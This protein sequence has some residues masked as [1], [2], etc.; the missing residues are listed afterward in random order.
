MATAQRKPVTLSKYLLLYSVGVSVLA[1][2]LPWCLLAVALVILALL[3]FREKIEEQTSWIEA[4]PGEELVGAV[5]FLLI[6]RCG[7]HS[8]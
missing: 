8:A 7:S 2:A 4:F 5:A 1:R 6:S 3:L